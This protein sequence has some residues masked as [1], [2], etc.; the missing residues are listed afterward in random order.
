MKNVGASWLAR[1]TTS[2]SARQSLQDPRERGPQRPRQRPRKRG[3]RFLGERVF[4]PRG[5]RRNGSSLRPSGRPGPRRASTVSR[6]ASRIATLHAFTVSAAR[7]RRWS[8]PTPGLRLRVGRRARRG[9]P[10]RCAVLRRPR[11]AGPRTGSPMPR[12]GPPARK[13]LARRRRTYPRPQLRG[14]NAEL[15]AFGRD[16][17]V[18]L[19]RGEQPATDAVAADHRDDR[20]VDLTPRT[21]RLRERIVVLRPGGHRGALATELRDVGAS[22]RTPGHRRRTTITCTS[23]SAA[24]ACR[25]RGTASCISWDIALR[26]AGLL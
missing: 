3:G 25:M 12:T 7:Q 8:P 17:D 1:S 9:S 20:L 6:C 5:S 15:A 4:V 24:N 14:G 19:H 2:G 23:G 18:G 16:P 10:I 13:Q 11:A 22:T 26:R 21:P